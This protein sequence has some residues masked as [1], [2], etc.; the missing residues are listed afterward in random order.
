MW[1]TDIM[2]IWGA[3]EKLLIEERILTEEGIMENVR[4]L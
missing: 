4:D 3:T 2:K 1:N